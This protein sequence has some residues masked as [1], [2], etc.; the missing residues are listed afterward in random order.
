[1]KLS[2]IIRRASPY[3]T[4]TQAWTYM[5]QHAA[6]V[7]EYLGSEQ[8]TCG[9]GELFPLPPT[10]CLV[11]YMIH[12][13]PSSEYMAISGC[14]LNHHLY[15]VVYMPVIFPKLGWIE[16]LRCKGLAYM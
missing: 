5:W 7:C 13:S 8:L 15:K 6:R 9:L 3:T 1:M 14:E 12:N 4:S 10:P 16:W 11:S 2:L